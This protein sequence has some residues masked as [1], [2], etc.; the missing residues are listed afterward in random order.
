[1]MITEATVLLE[2]AD[3]WQPTIQ[4]GAVEVEPE[5]VYIYGSGV[6]DPTAIREVTFHPMRK[7]VRIM[8]VA[9]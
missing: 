3:G 5:G 2:K 1:M 7:V 6:G 4:G 8:G 9:T